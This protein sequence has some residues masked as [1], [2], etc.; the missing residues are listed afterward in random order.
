VTHSSNAKNTP[1]YPVPVVRLIVP[2]TD[3]HVLVVRRR[4]GGYAP[5][6]W[7]LPGGKV[8][9]GDTVER[10]VA[11]ELTEETALKCTSAE[12][13]FFQDSLP[14][15]PGQMHCINLYFRCAAQGKIVLNPE[16]SEHAWIG[17]DDL[18]HYALAFR[19][20]EG[21]QRYWSES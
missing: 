17:P 10:T 8:D 15:A 1:G 14:L 18:D 5:G 19:N 16:S 9:Y 7:C 3:G 11:K 21:L 13:L 20:D 4:G 2:D 6:D 12:F